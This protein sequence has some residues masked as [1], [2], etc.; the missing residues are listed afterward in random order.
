MISVGISVTFT[1]C[2]LKESN[3]VNFLCFL[4]TIKVQIQYSVN[5]IKLF[6]IPINIHVNYL[7]LHTLV[8]E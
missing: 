2:Q 3:H 5:G 4:D 1:A 7:E 8:T 6:I